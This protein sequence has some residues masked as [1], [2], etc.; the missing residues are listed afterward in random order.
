[1]L[2]DLPAPRLAFK[3]LGDDLAELA[4]SKAAAFA[5]G[6]G[7]GLDDPFDRQVIRQLA[8]A[9]WR[10]LARLRGGFRRGNF[11]L[12]LFLGLRFLEVLDRQ[13]ELLDE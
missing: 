11:G 12:G 2:D 7:G 3:R 4:Q 8:R 5:A 13:F 1:M 6:A 9:A 10:A